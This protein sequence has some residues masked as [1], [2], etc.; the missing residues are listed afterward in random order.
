MEMVTQTVPQCNGIRYLPEPFLVGERKGKEMTTSLVSWY[1]ITL[2]HINKE[3]EEKLAKKY[4][5]FIDHDAVVIN[6]DGT[7]TAY[8][9]GPH[10]LNTTE[11]CRIPEVKSIEDAFSPS[12]AS[13][14]D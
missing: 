2:T 9:T 12:C 6:E 1:N 5:I 3:V 7:K 10:Q 11:I 13:W 14:R 8:A 4:Y